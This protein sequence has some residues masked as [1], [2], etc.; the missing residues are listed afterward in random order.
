M[1]HLA[2]SYSA[3]G[4]GWLE[5]L[6]FQQR[7]TFVPADAWVLETWVLPPLSNSW[8]IFIIWIY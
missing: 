1:L 6:Y 4:F 8:I 3:V 5:E 2:H 7:V